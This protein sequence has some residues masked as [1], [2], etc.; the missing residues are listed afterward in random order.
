M[1]SNVLVDRQKQ[2]FIQ[3][4]KAV[5]KKHPEDKE[6]VK[7]YVLGFSPFD[8]NKYWLWTK[9]RHPNYLGEYMCW[10]SFC[11]TA[12]PS[13]LDLN[14]TAPKEAPWLVPCCFFGLY[15]VARFF[16]DCLVHW[17][18]AAPAEV[19][20]VSRRPLYKHYQLSTPVLFPATVPLFPQYR[21][22]GWPFPEE[23]KD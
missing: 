15:L 5:A 3:E 7:S 9:S 17:T 22:S 6:K 14:A 10:L 21:Q 2:L 16:Y 13:V 20:S 23:K 11:I 19:G 18:G 1:F 8:G 12:V 4:C